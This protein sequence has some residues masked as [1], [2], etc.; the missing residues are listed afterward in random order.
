[1]IESTS[2]LLALLKQRDIRLWVDGDRLRFSA[3]KDALTPE[4]SERIAAH[5][6]AL[7]ALLQGAAE[8][9]TDT[10][11]LQPFTRSSPLPLSFAQQHMWLLEQLHPNNQAYHIA[12]ARGC[13][14]DQ[15]RNLAKSVTVE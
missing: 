10:P 5:R 7:L 1:M 9:L 3:P 12:V 4:L 13:S 14:V 6:S 11:P 2:D 8:S 15:P